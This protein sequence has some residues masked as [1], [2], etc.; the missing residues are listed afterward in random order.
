[1]CVCVYTSDDESQ[2]AA[3]GAALAEIL[4][5]GTTVGLF[6]TLG[7]GKTRL[8]QVIHEYS[9]RRKIVHIDAYRL[10]DLDE[11]LALGPEEYFQSDGVV[12]VEWADRVQE[13]LPPERI[14]IQLEVTG[15]ARR[16]FEVR[17]VGEK[18][19]PLVARL[20]TA[21]SGSDAASY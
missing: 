20:A 21:L 12:L 5:E 19:H 14:D 4:P 3:L 7:A 15:A 11:F 6:G 2:T 13:A 17:A 9:G 10:K 16:R 8:V 18:Y 1:M